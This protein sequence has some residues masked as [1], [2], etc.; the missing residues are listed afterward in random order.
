M[1]SPSAKKKKKTIKKKWLPEGNQSKLWGQLNNQSFCVDEFSG[2]TGGGKGEVNLD[3]L[4]DLLSMSR[5]K[6]MNDSF[7]V[8]NY[9]VEN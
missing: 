3:L 5:S 1:G 9:I 2:V 7:T 4:E 8:R 6:L